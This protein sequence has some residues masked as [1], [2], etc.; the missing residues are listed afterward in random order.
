LQVID[1]RS[2]VGY[3]HIGATQR[4]QAQVIEPRLEIY[5]IGCGNPDSWSFAGLAP[6]AQGRA[7]VIRVRD[8]QYM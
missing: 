1:D 4:V 5:R 2:E 3:R 8:A 6:H 7:T